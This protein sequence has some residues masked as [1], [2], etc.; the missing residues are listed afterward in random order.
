MWRLATVMCLACLLLAQPALGQ[1][2][3]ALVVGIDR[4]DNL[5]PRAQLK[6]ARADARAVAETLRRLG[7]DVLL[8]EDATRPLFNA[9]WQD[10]LN[11]LSAGDTAAFYFAGHGIELGGRNYLLPRDV[12]SVRPGRDELL[13]RESLSLQEFLA[14]LRE[15]GTRLNLVILDAC[16][17]NPF[18]Q[19]AGRSVGAA[20]GLAVTE[21]PEGTFIMFSA[22]T[23]E[24]ALDRLDD[25]DADP[26]SVYTRSLLPLLRS[27]GLTLTDVA[28][29]VRIGVRELSGTVQHRQTPAYYNQV[30]GRVCLAGGEC[31]ASR[32]AATGAQSVSEAERAWAAIKETNS[33]VV[34]E[35][36]VARFTDTFYGDLA[37]QRIVELRQTATAA[38]PVQAPKSATAKDAQLAAIAPQPTPESRPPAQSA[39]PLVPA[40]KAGSACPAGAVAVAVKGEAARRCL[41]PGK[42]TFR[43]CPA[44]PEMVVMPTGRV[45]VGS[46]ESEPGRD[47]DEGPQVAVAIARPY[48]V[49]RFVVT[50]D[51]W[52][53]C[54]AEGGCNGIRPA[55]DGWGRGRLPVI[56]IS[57]GDANSYVAWL[58]RKTGAH[59]RLPS[60]AEWEHAARAGTTTPYWWGTNA[61]AD[62]ANFNSDGASGRTVAVDKFAPNGWGLHQMSGNVWQWTGDCWSPGHRDT[63]LDGSSKAGGDCSRRVIRGGSWNTE[64][65]LLRS[66]SRFPDHAD[67]RFNALGFRI[68]RGIEP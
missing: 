39:P 23:G 55:D 6:K 36:Y 45:M 10:F 12:P 50:F 4:Y 64:G 30:L 31:G 33:L 41:L 18:E 11:K 59:Y 21:P 15:K 56:N 54:V 67:D 46:P 26:N 68:A 19:A 17:D 48:A 52:D 16:R 25:S 20:R 8:K 47:A 1:K 7:F 57:W 13:K 44:C 3:A 61:S 60:E 34:L 62:R 9:T 29:Q 58:S 35:A 27:S 63:P 38:K 51:E 42:D 2:R 65:R 32:P 24:S 28:E 14:D 40:K 53:A 22:G 49:G 43:D 5:E 66:A 37:R